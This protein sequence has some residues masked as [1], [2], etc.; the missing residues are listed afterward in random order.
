MRGKR[1]K[2]RKCYVLRTSDG[3]VVE[4]T[5]EVYLEWYQSRRRERYQNEKKQIYS[6]TSL[7]ALS[8]KGMI[9]DG[10]ADSLEDTVIRKICVE[11]LQSVMEE[12]AKRTLIYCIC[13]F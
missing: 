6:V 9:L 5:R 12:L 13:C 8:E 2:E 3:T 11:K 4:V 1:P 10:M 7:E